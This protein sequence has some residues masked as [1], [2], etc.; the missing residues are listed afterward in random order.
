VFTP[1]PFR[2]CA[3]YGQSVTKKIATMVW[4]QNLN[5]KG[6]KEFCDYLLSQMSEEQAYWYNKVLKGSILPLFDNL[7]DDSLQVDELFKRKV[8]FT[9]AICSLNTGIFSYLTPDKD[10][11]TTIG[12]RFDGIKE[13]LR[14]KV[15]WSA[16]D[17]VESDEHK[18]WYVLNRNCD[19]EDIF[20]HMIAYEA[21]DE[22]YLSLVLNSIDHGIQIS[23]QEE[24][25]LYRV[26]ISQEYLEMASQA[27]PG[28]IEAFEDSLESFSNINIVHDIDHVC[29]RLLMR[30]TSKRPSEETLILESTYEL[31]M[32]LEQ[33]IEQYSQ[34]DA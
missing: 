19:I 32:N 24:D 27:K 1:T 4:R 16:L 28:A 11:E 12:R 10:K 2:L 33:R 8:R 26:C 7:A 20:N 3:T 21:Q 22:R 5:V 34:I 29:N 17:K 18:I 6:S 9:F 25:S 30:S 14:T 15:D 31:F 13:M 23:D